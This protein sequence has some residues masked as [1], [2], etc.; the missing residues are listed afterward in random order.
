MNCGTMCRYEVGKTGGGPDGSF[1]ALAGTTV[2]DG[3]AGPVGESPHS[4]REALKIDTIEPRL[5]VLYE[6]VLTIAKQKK[7]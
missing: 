2:I 6:T 4:T 7:G 3:G 5:Q 1:A